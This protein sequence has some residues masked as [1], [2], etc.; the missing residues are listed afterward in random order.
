MKPDH[1]LDMIAEMAG[2]CVLMRTRLVSR[3]VTGIYDQELRP[4]GLNSP[5]F[6]LLVVIAKL[7]PST[8]AEIG[9]YHHQDR[10]TLTRNLQVMLAEGWIAEASDG[11]SGRGRPIVLT[12]TG[13]NLLRAVVPAWRAAQTQAKI[14]L[15]Q[16][17]VLAIRE[18]ADGIMNLTEQ[19]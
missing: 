1:N 19:A 5:Q 3:V 7:G 15:G 8:R 4:F 13:R 16:S 11:S 12:K 6:A 18:I 17:G 2:T 14:T 10:S 9:R